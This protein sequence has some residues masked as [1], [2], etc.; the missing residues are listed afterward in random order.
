MSDSK[1]LA[2]PPDLAGI[3]SQYMDPADVGAAT[4]V[5]TSPQPRSSTKMTVYVSYVPRLRSFSAHKE[6][7]GEVRASS[8][9]DLLAKLAELWPDVEFTLVLSKVARAEFAARRK[10]VPRAEGWT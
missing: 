10:G 9:P 6:G 7:L 5:T 3:L 2:L 1:P 4:L 8:M